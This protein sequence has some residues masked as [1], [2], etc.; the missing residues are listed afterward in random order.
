[1]KLEAFAGLKEGAWHPTGSKPEQ[2]SAFR[3]RGF[4]EGG[5]FCFDSFERGNGVHDLNRVFL[6]RGV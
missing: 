4:N 6:K 3:Q 1:M 5:D 2:P